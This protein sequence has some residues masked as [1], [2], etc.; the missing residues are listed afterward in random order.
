MPRACS[1]Q[2]AQFLA[3]GAKQTEQKDESASE[4]PASGKESE[5]AT[6]KQEKGE[7]EEEK[8]EA[9]GQEGGPAAAAPPATGSHA[10]EN[11]QPEPIP[12]SGKWGFTHTKG[13][14]H[15]CGSDNKQWCCDRG[16]QF[17]V[18]Q[19]RCD[20]TKGHNA[21]VMSVAGLISDFQNSTKI[22]RIPDQV[23]HNGVR[24]CTHKNA[25]ACKDEE[26]KLC[27]CNAGFIYSFPE[28]E[29]E[30]D[31][32]DPK[33][34]EDPVPGSDKW[35]LLHRVGQASKC[36][37]H[38]K[39]Y[40]CHRMCQ[41]EIGHDRCGE[42]VSYEQAPPPKA[43]EV[44]NKY[45]GEKGNY[46]IPPK[47]DKPGLMGGCST[48]NA[49]KCTVPTSG[50]KHCCCHQGFAFSFVSRQC[51]APAAWQSEQ[52]QDMPQAPGQQGHQGPQGQA[53][54]EGQGQNQHGQPQNGQGP[55]PPPQGEEV[56]VP[57]SVATLAGFAPLLLMSK[58]LL[59]LA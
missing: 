18:E 53:G 2:R 11:F 20:P 54:Q 17:N 3:D 32:A 24:G 5:E 45:V 27:C 9:S 19:D 22:F 34:I 31:T 33:N 6:T 50:E 26:Q 39:K 52:Q 46:V 35:G 12:G 16:S 51:L 56:G 48:K 8:G 13:N 43:W 15:K 29:C 49:K 55:A 40:C 47:I 36:V 30:A 42:C 21:T 41:Y 10:A 14:A 23:D 44:I 28:R 38:P 59:L 1:A 4:T 37:N 58:F 57:R 7:K 25:V